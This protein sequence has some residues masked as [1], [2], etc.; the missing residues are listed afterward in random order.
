MI[1]SRFTPPI[2]GKLALV[3]AFLMLALAGCSK[4]DVSSDTDPVV[5]HLPT[6]RL[7][8]IMPLPILRV[9][10]HQVWHRL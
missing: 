3:A 5:S 6:A 2:L 4:D 10:L 7:P 1:I 9:S 8:V